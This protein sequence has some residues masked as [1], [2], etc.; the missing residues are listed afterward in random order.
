MVLLVC[1]L[2]LICSPVR[3]TRSSAT[4]IA[5]ANPSS[6]SSLS[7][8]PIQLARRSNLVEGFFSKFPR[9]VLRHIR[10]ESKEEL[11]DRIM[12]AMDYFNQEPVVHTWS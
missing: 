10:V 6:F 9:S 3:F 2:V 4:V 5:A 12:P 8:L 1:W 7:M 11:K